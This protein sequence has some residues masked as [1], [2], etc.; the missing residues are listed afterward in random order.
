MR[1]WLILLGVGVGTYV[2]RVAF[3]VTADRVAPAKV[4]KALAYVGPAVLAAIAV[5]ALFAPRG[6]ISVAETVPSLV[7]GLAAW[8]L[9]RRT[10]LVAVSLLGALGV[11][12][13]A[14]AAATL[15]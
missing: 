4:T 1:D 10:Q 13:A 8:L 6:A 11:W 15:V 5:P 7:A 2:L 9:W 12:W 3:L 14:L